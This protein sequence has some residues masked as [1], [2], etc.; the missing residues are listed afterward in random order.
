[1]KST[2]S[3]CTRFAVLL[4]GRSRAVPS[5]IRITRVASRGEVELGFHVLTDEAATGEIVPEAN[6]RLADEPRGAIGLT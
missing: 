1:M 2:R 6:G 4:G 5:C 3:S